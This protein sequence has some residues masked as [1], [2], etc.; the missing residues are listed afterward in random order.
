[1]IGW[2]ECRTQLGHQTHG[3]LQ[4]SSWFGRQHRV[5]ER[6]FLVGQGNPVEVGQPAS[7]SR[8]GHVVDRIEPVQDRLGAQSRPV[9]ELAGITGRMGAVEL[10][11]TVPE[12]RGEQLSVGAPP[13][14]SLR[15]AP[16]EYSL[17]QVRA[18]PE[19]VDDAMSMLA[20]E[21]SG[22]VI[23]PQVGELWSSVLTT[24]RAALS[25]APLLSE[26]LDDPVVVTTVVDERLTITG[27]PAHASSLEP[28]TRMP[29]TFSGYR[30][31]C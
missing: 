19:S 22:E 29:P 31:R 17:L 15:C 8:K 3:R 23:A 13:E 28:T 9:P 26:L 21:W 18:T 25:L 10:R 20:S 1:M 14:A 12:E 6:V 27:S 30:Y 4:A 11:L 5:D 24:E 7:T 16:V 2:T